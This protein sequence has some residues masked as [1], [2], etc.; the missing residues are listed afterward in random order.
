MAI[1]AMSAIVATLGQMATIAVAIMK[2]GEIV[3]ISIMAILITD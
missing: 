2:A 3:K 1:A